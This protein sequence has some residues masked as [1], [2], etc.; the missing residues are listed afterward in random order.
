MKDRVFLL[1]YLA[2]VVGTTSIHDTRILAAGLAGV[3]VLAGRDLPIVLKRAVLTVLVFTTVV[4]LSYAALSL[5]QDRFSGRY[6]LLLNL[7]VLLLASMTH[8]LIRRADLFSALGFSRS[9]RFLAVLAYG[10][11]LLFRRLTRETRDAFVSRS[12]TRPGLLTRYR[13]SGATGSLLYGKSIRN[14]VETGQAMRSRGLF[15]D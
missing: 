2:A 3:L 5:L 1:V 7:R 13:R 9:L 12:I 6:L 10:Q 8:L 14:A 15:L 4:S 11:I